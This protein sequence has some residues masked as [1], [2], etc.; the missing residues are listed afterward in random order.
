[1]HDGGTAV[2]LSIN[3]KKYCTSNALYGG[4]GG[5]LNIDGKAWETIRKMEECNTPIPVK[6][7]DILKVEAAYDTKKHPL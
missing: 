5:T 4:E 1:M 3:G 2:T 7:G 6:K